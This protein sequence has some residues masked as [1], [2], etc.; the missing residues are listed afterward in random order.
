MDSEFNTG[1]GWFMSYFDGHFSASMPGIGP[2]SFRADMAVFPEDNL[3]WILLTNSGATN[4]S[5]VGD[6]LIRT[7][8]SGE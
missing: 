5:G 7:V 2:P 3:M 6:T 1:Y 8:F 4:T